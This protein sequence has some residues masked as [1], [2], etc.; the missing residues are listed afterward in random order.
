MK[1]GN[2]I[3]IYL[4]QP[5][6]NFTSTSGNKASP[7]V[8]FVSPWHLPINFLQDETH[9]EIPAGNNPGGL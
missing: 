5:K 8:Y 2:A 7:T 9:E 3:K 6:L 4:N 1:A